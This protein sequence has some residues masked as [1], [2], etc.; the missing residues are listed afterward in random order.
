MFNGQKMS[1]V[2]AAINVLLLLTVTR[3]FQTKRATKFC[4][5]PIYLALDQEDHE[6]FARQIMNVSDLEYQT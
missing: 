6:D 5:R 4:T 1:E 3:V 2:N